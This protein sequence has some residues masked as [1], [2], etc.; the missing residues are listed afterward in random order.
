MIALWSSPVIPPRSRPLRTLSLAV[1]LAVGCT[2]PP[3][4]PP[5]TAEN[6][7]LAEA[8][9]HQKAQSGEIERLEHE[10]DRLKADLREAEESMVAIESG[11]LGAHTRA[12]A[13][14]VLADARIAVES[15][16]TAAPWREDAITEAR[17]KLEEAE[18]Q[19]QSGRPGT[20]VFFASRANRIAINLV[21]E[22]EEVA[23]EKSTRF[24]RGRR[25]NLRA[26]PST[27]DAVIAVLPD[28]TPVHPD[29]DEGQ[30]VLLRT[31][32]GQVGWVHRSLLR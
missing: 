10:I 13:V 22:A 8:V 5:I 2:S 12:Q 26:G 18:R 30:W 15:S 1:G 6:R 16:A 11:L 4:S 31:R 28:S 17:G 21:S 25:V 9:V 7:T 20:A 3:T 14:S 24:I 23:A 19:F 27:S 32:D 29:R